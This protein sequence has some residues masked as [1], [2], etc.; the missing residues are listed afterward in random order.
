[1]I[2]SLHFKFKVIMTEPIIIK[3]PS[4]EV[5]KLFE[6]MRVHK[7]RQLD[8]MKDMKRGMFSIKV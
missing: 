7:V 8:K 3:H 2:L 4:E 5:L 1:M 6:M